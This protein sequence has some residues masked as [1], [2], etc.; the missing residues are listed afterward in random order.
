[1][2]IRIKVATTAK[3]LSD[4]YRLRYQVYVVEEGLYGSVSG[5][6]IIDRFDALP[7]T[8]NIIA[9][10]GATPV[11]TMRTNFDS[12]V[13]LPA[14]E[15]YDFS[16]Y[17]E[18][19]NEQAQAQGL[20]RALLGCSGMLAIAKKWRNRRDLFRA[21]FKLSCDVGHSWGVSHIIVTAR[22]E[23]QSMYRRMGFE[24]LEDELWYEPAGAHIVPMVSELERIYQW[25]FGGM[26][27]KSDLLERFSGCFQYL[28]FSAGDSIFCEGDQGD[29]AYIVSA[30]AVDISRKEGDDQ[31][32]LATLST[33][34]LFGELS[35][36]DEQARSADATAAKNTELVVLNRKTFWDK[37]HDDPEYLR[38]LLS[39]LSKRLRDVDDRA[40]AYAHGSTDYRLNFFLNKVK[41]HALPLNKSP[42]DSKAKISTTAFAYMASARLEEALAFLDQLQLEG[43]LKYTDTSITF[44]GEQTQ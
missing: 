14:D 16:E 43:K 30:G 19:A 18:R 28:L 31:L 38:S 35:L 6:I 13:L 17:R 24:A 39:I 8:A 23:A 26:V 12:E 37:A 22:S 11:G 41:A 15:S 1:M 33:G 4:V 3:E 2:S 21:L 44:Y 7:N 25:A 20:D 27:G 40:F 5:D 29:E 42:Q 32:N 9:Y 36:I 10:E 34:S